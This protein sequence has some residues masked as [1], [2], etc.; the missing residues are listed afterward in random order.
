MNI[1]LKNPFIF[2]ITAGYNVKNS[3]KN[4]EKVLGQLF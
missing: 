3:Y 2:G 4:L 1:E